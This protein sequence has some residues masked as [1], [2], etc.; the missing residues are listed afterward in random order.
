M[1]E[2]KAQPLTH[3][4]FAKYGE[5]VNL[6]DDASHAR[7]TIRTEG[8]FPDLSVLTFGTSTQPT[9]S[10]CSAKK[11]EKNVVDFL[12]YHAYTCEGLITLDADV[13]IYVGIPDKQH[14]MR[15]ENCESFIIPKGYFVKLNPYIIHG[16]QYPIDAETAHLVCLLPQRTF[17]NDM[18]KAVLT[19]DEERGVI[20][21]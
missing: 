7:N 11:K 21:L 1:R 19:T 5:Y 16:T 15:I 9:V 14:N 17:H 6:L 12:E 3:E 13:A 20:V 4:A 10:V 8:F 2:L 18:F